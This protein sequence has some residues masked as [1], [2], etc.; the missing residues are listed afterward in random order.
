[1]T[2]KYF[3]LVS[4]D[5]GYV[6]VPSNSGV[7]VEIH[8]NFC[9]GQDF[10]RTCTVEEIYDAEI[11]VRWVKVYWFRSR[12]GDGKKGIALVKF[13]LT[14]DCLLYTSPSLREYREDYDCEIDFDMVLMTEGEFE[15]ARQF[16]DKGRDIR[17]AL[18]LARALGFC[19][20]RFLGT[21]TP[22]IP[23]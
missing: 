14:E 8:H 7:K 13:K 22:T 12:C 20:A 15:I 2:Y 16:F 9:H 6:L 10:S 4:V 17:D 21:K 3:A 19:V 18:A 5:G 1:M 23:Y 11:F